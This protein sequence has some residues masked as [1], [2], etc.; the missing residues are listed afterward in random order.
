[1]T[2]LKQKLLDAGYPEDMMFHHD[3]D[4]YVFANPITKYI[5]NE[6]CQKNGLHRH[7]FVST[8]TDQLTGQLMYD[9]AF[10]WHE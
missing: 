10:Q 9:I 3:S 1:M 5:I 6:W 8:F 2:D 4:L 7:L